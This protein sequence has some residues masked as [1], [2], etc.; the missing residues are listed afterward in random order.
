M[1]YRIVNVACVLALSKPIHA[2]H[3]DNHD[4]KDRRDRDQDGEQA[5]VK[6]APVRITGSESV[7]LRRAA[8][9][10]DR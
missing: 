5:L 9:R 7:A 6:R 4:E 10:S 3:V 8:V 2:H 1:F